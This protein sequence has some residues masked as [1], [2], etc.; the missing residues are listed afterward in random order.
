MTAQTS[1]NSGAERSTN[2]ADLV[3]QAASQ[4]S[5]LVR[6]E[7]A[8]AKRELAEKGKRAGLGGGLL[9]GAAVLGLYGLGLL[10]VLAV[11]LLDLAW[12]LWLAVLVVMVV[13]FAAAAVAALLGRRRL[14][15][16]TP[17]VPTDAIAGVEADLATV[18]TAARRGRH[19]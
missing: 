4:I 14:E 7:L 10:L 17:P 6:D 18:K 3:S 8:L 13:V 1:P 9:G 12:P 19:A 15:E 2:T 16:A 11:V 5:T